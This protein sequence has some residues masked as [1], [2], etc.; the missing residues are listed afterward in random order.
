M[1][2]HA[3]T[4]KI[5]VEE[6]GTLARILTE[7]QEWTEEQ[8]AWLAQPLIANNPSNRQV[9]YMMGQPVSK[10]GLGINRT[11]EAVE[12][13]RRRNRERIA[14]YANGSKPHTLAVAVAPTHNIVDATPVV[15]VAP[16]QPK[17][18]DEEYDP[19][20]LGPELVIPHSANLCVSSDWHAKDTDFD[21]ITRIGRVAKATRCFASAIV[22]DIVN[23]EEFS[24]HG[25]ELRRVTPFVDE[26]AVA[27]KAIAALAKYTPTIFIC[28]GNHDYW[29][30]RF[31]MGAYSPEMFINQIT[32]RGMEIISAAEYMAGARPKGAAVV[33]TARTYMYFGAAGERQRWVLAH[34]PGYGKLVGQYHQKQAQKFADCHVWQAHDHNWGQGYLL[35]GKRYVSGGMVADPS[36]LRY[37]QKNAETFPFMQQGFGVIVPSRAADEEDDVLLFNNQHT[38]WAMWEY[39]LET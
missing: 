32:P 10:G 34:G 39:L 23:G 8:I 28:M 25:R 13:F 5:L 36:K 38:N 29:S 19:T 18:G 30:T 7:G 14:Q 24:P 2:V 15:K 35:N 31:A 1:Q 12:T 4:A 20:E 27:K 33:W 6:R 16:P 37:H 17:A 21:F 9:A 3:A 26:L 22:G 11:R